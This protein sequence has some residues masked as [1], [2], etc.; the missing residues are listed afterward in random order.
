MALM[1]DHQRNQIFTLCRELGWTD[2]MRHEMMREW[3][4]KT[5]LAADAADPVTEEEARRLFDRL[6]DAVMRVR[7]ERRLARRRQRRVWREPRPTP[8]Q[9]YRIGVLV[10]AV[11]GGDRESFRGWLRK[12]YDV[13]RPELLTPRQAIGCIVGLQRMKEQGWRPRRQVRKQAGAKEVV[14]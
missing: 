7:R 14:E 13:E 1:N 2:Q 12:R 4:G 9:V 3:I 5:S 10:R 11:F 8:E 6:G